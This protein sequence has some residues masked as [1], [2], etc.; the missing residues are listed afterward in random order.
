MSSTAEQVKKIVIDHLGI[1]ESKITLESNKLFKWI[2]VPLVSMP[3][4]PALP[5]FWVYS[6]GKR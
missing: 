5:A 4:R 2:T 1:D 6:C 3:R